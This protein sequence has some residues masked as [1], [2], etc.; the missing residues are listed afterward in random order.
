MGNIEGRLLKEILK[1]WPMVTS[2]SLVRGEGKVV[3]EKALVGIRSQIT[4][5]L[6]GL[7]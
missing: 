7:I 5:S 2:E 6:R 4:D 3:E 1:S